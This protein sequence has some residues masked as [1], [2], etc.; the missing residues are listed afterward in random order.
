[1]KKCAKR[2]CY[3]KFKDDADFL[4]SLHGQ[5]ASDRAFMNIKD[6]LYIVV[7]IGWAIYFISVFVQIHDDGFRQIW[8]SD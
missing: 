4:L 2:E 5:F 7:K 1:L 8:L 3:K 6:L